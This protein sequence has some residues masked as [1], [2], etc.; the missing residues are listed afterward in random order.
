M[1]KTDEHYFHMFA[2][3]DDAKNFITTELEFKLAFNRFAVCAH[4]SGAIVLSFSVENTHPH[5]LLWGTYGQCTDFKERYESMSIK[6]IVRR[7]GSAQDVCLHCEI[8]EITDEA[9]LRN[10]GTYTIVQATK[11]GKPVMPYDYLYGTG[12]LYFR[13]KRAILPWMLDEDGTLCTPVPLNSLPVRVR[14]QLCGTK[15]LLPGEWLTCNGFILPTNYVD[16]Q[17]FENIYRT[18]NCY[19]AFLCSK[20]SQDDAIMKQMSDTRGVVIDDLLARQLCAEACQN[21]FGRTSTAHLN[22]DE[23]LL[24]AQHLRRTFQLSYRQVAI[25][26]HIPKFELQK[27]VK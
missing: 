26:V 27:Y 2:N 10:V 8:Y 14:Q 22:I 21:L 19:R 18:H 23:R 17:R 15:M 16:I 4:H 7:R 24:L 6:S 13:D 5:A 3:G 25:L 12:S 1:S 11:D 20:K 9:Y